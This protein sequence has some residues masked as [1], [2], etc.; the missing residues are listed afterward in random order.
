MTAPDM[1]RPAL[2]TFAPGSV[3]LAGAG[4]G[5]P[6][7][8]TLHTLNGLDQADVVVHDAL[9]APEILALANP[10]A[11]LE[12]A[13]KRGGRPSP[14]QDAIS[15]RLIV[16]AGRGLKVLRL[17]GG[18]PFVFGRGAEEGAALTAAGI[19]WR[20][21]PGITA[22]LG[23]L[24]A[25]G[26]PATARETNRGII[27]A[28]G[29]PAAGADPGPD[30]ATLAATGLPIVLYM[31]MSGLPG[32]A[33]GLM[34]GGLSPDTPVALVAEATTPAQ[35]V[36]VTRLADAAATAEATGLGAPAIVAIGDIVALRAALA[37][38][39]LSL[40]GAPALEQTA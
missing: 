9:V 30:W 33:A 26:I 27:L 8:L 39:L 15:A 20:V 28:T 23:G 34:A 6:G 37:P 40:S 10:S 1:R 22:G 4:P 5:D 24:A 38:T 11:R 17:K 25:A 21:I 16:L 18:D 7:L 2:P 29:H 31:A 35:R 36:L 32:I 14:K 3:W 19:P 12:L 13:G